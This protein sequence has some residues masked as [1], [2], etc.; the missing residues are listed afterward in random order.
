M[1]IPLYYQ[2][3]EYDCGPTSIINGL[4]YL[5][6]REEFPPELIRRIMSY[7]LDSFDDS[8]RACRRGTTAEALRFISCWLGNY[9]AARSF[10]VRAVFLEQEQVH[11]GEGSLILDALLKGGAVILHMFYECGHYVLLTGLEGSDRL[12]MFDCYYEEGEDLDLLEQAGIEIVHDRPFK[13]NRI[14]PIQRLDS[15]ETGSYQ[16]GPVNTRE[17]VLLFRTDT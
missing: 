10:P 2:R 12:C 3:S 4:S 16:L 17:A 1:K 11:L 15:T 8:G 9:G 7:S 14:V 5:F 13:M 6:D